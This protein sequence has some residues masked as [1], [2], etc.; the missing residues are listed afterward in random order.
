MIVLA[1]VLISIGV[2]FN[3]ALLRLLKLAARERDVLGGREL[4][5]ARASR[6]RRSPWQ[7]TP[8][9]VSD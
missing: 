4:A 9:S 5:Q 8:R 2:L 6:I 3:I 7:A 1:I